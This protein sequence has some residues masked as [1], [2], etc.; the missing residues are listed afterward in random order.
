MRIPS[1][2][3]IPLTW[4]YWVHFNASRCKD[5]KWPVVIR[6]LRPSHHRQEVLSCFHSIPIALTCSRSLLLLGSRVWDSNSALSWRILLPHLHG[7]LPPSCLGR[8]H[9]LSCY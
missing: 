4:L 2:P 9:N 3:T 1:I 6:H 5:K 7:L 8:T